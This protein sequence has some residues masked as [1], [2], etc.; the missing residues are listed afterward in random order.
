MTKQNFL[1]KHNVTE[2]R[3]IKCNKKKKIIHVILSWQQRAPAS[4][5][6]CCLFSQT[7]IAA[8]TWVVKF[9]C[10]S[11]PNGTTL[12]FHKSCIVNFQMKSKKGRV[13][14]QR[15]S[16]M[17]R[18][19]IGFVCAGCFLSSGVSQQLQS[20]QLWHR[21]SVLNLCRGKTFLPSSASCF[22]RLYHFISA[23]TAHII[24]SLSIWQPSLFYLSWITLVLH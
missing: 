10:N 3:Y 14:F 11:S 1:K 4:Y 16:S 9:A 20:R 21:F 19:H 12:A 2:V 6:S 13:Y 7:C 23:S 15:T 24:S 17:Q 22:P 5:Y 8:F 18:T